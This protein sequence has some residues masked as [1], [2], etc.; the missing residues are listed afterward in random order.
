MSLTANGL[1]AALIDTFNTPSI[2][3][4]AMS[5]SGATAPTFT[6]ASSGAQTV[7]TNGEWRTANAPVL[8]AVGSGPTV[9]IDVTG[10][11]V[12]IENSSSIT[13]TLVGINSSAQGLAVLNAPGSTIASVGFG[14][15]AATPLVTNAA[16]LLINRGDIVGPS[17]GFDDRSAVSTNRSLTILNEGGELNAANGVIMT[18]PSSSDARTLT[19]V[20]G[21]IRARRTGITNTDPS[22]PLGADTNVVINNSANIFAGSSGAGYGIELSCL[23]CVAGVANQGAIT[24]RDAGIRI[25]SGTNVSLGALG[26]P[27]TLQNS[28][29]I[30]VSNGAAIS[31]FGTRLTQITNSA[32]LTASGDGI[33]LSGAGTLGDSVVTNSGRII[34]GANG[35]F[36]SASRGLVVTNTGDVTAG[37]GTGLHANSFRSFASPGSDIHVTNTALVSSSAGDGMR[38]VGG[39]SCM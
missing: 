2:G 38:T 6:I 11:N 4:T 34:A 13:G 22:S 9:A 25:F 19:I 17:A 28:G 39:S 27:I 29:A 18:P 1:N 3:G 16:T 37:T 36:A 26:G 24:A 20:G 33:S 12:V 31:V 35:I 5:V 10:Q 32:A 7:S 21:E 8:S 14:G 15:T 23:Q 30:N